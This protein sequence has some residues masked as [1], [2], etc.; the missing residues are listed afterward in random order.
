MPG[1]DEAPGL[2]PHK[3]THFEVPRS[4]SKGDQ[5]ETAVSIM[6]VGIQHKS[7]LWK[8]L[9]VPKRFKKRRRA[10]SSVRR[11]PAA[12]ATAWAPDSF[13]IWL[14]FSAI[15]ESAWSQETRSHLFSPF[16]PARLSG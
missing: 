2:K 14:S 6:K 7:A 3:M 15:S 5:P 10:Q 9:G 11:V 16:S 8:P 4:V 1:I 13:L 12:A